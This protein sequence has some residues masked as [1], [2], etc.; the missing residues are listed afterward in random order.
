MLRQFPPSS[1][2]IAFFLQQL[3]TQ[4]YIMKVFT[5]CPRGKLQLCQAVLLNEATQQVRVAISW[6][7]K[8]S[9]LLPSLET[10][11]SVFAVFVQQTLFIGMRRGAINSLAKQVLYK[12]NAGDHSRQRSLEKKTNTSRI[13]SILQKWKSG[14]LER[15]V[16][17]R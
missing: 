11:W 1:H 2:Q 8:D 7:H 15:G 13:V 10:R 5:Y 4:Q 6:R 3:P 9:S 12:P 14:Y 16:I 17:Y